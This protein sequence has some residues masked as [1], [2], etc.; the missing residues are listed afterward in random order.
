MVQ[1]EPLS[2][3]EGQCQHPEEEMWRVNDSGLDTRWEFKIELI[4]FN[5]FKGWNEFIQIQPLKKDA[6]E[7]YIYYKKQQKRQQQKKQTWI[8]HFGKQFTVLSKNE[9]TAR[10]RLALG[11][12]N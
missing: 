7:N 1:P 10:R 5:L 4:P 8:W 2:L 3:W 12:N 6:A 9:A 11:G